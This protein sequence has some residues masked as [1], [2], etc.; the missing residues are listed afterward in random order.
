MLTQA[1]QHTIEILNY[2]RVL[3]PVEI[4]DFCFLM[5]KEHGSKYRKH[6]RGILEH[7]LLLLEDW[8]EKM[9]VY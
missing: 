5:F 7:Y 3:S 9:V 6:Y 2:D 1:Q 8:N 4:I